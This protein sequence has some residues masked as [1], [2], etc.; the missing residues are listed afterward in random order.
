MPSK[1]IERYDQVPVTKEDREWCLISCYFSC[2]WQLAG[3]L[4]DWAELIT[5]DLSQYE[6]PG[7]KEDL[8]KQ[9]DHAVRNVG[10]SISSCTTCQARDLYET[11]PKLHFNWTWSSGL[12]LIRVWKQDSSMWRTSTSVKKILTT[13][14]LWG[15]S[16]M[17]CHLKRSSNSTAP[18]TLKG[19]NTILI[20]LQDTECKKQIASRDKF[21]QH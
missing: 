15:G 17:P 11:I 3:G 14:S 4:V 6:Q 2:C 19:V 5:L 9:L 20:V 21:I 7:G 12:V 13:S 18:V 10:E 1:Y 16:S 8:V